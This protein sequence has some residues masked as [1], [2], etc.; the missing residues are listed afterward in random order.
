MK[1]NKRIITSIFLT[2]FLS[3]AWSQEWLNIVDTSALGEISFATIRNSKTYNIKNSAN[4]LKE[5]L[6]TEKNTDFVLYKVTIDNRGGTHE[7]YRQTFKNISV[8][9]CEFIVHKDSRGYIE[10]ING[11]F[12]RIQ[13]DFSINPKFSFND[14]LEILKIS[15]STKYSVKELPAK[16]R[17][18]EAS[19]DY[20]KKSELVIIE[21]KDKIYY[22]T[23][24]TVLESNGNTSVIGFID[25]NTGSLIKAKPINEPT[26]FTS[27]PHI[28][29]S[30]VGNA[31][32]N[33]TGTA[34]SMYL[35]DINLV[36]DYSSGTYRLTESNRGGTSTPISTLD[37]N[38]APAL[39]D[40]DVTA[41]ILGASLITDNDNIW[42]YNEHQ[43]DYQA[44]DV[45]WGLE[46]SFDYFAIEHNWTSFDNNSSPIVGY[47][48]VNTRNSLNN[49]VIPW[50]NASWNYINE[51]FFVW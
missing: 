16:L 3:S 17:Y 26:S 4:L 24:K 50:D 2:F 47:V 35:E 29:S 5:V 36:T 27:L 14:A 21:G 38:G 44:T 46:Q 42:N 13:D 18:N 30:L 51:V 10:S 15:S 11:D 7:K 28:N 19:S 33:S 40:S 12:L 31:Q 37:F 48:H 43:L 34:Q 41:G 8:D 39:Y 25:C 1:T 49:N 23:Y 22:L 32:F 45:H 20:E 6:K 9:F